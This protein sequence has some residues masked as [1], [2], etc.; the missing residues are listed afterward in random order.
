MTNAERD[1][2]GKNPHLPVLVRD[3]MTATAV[4]V[5]PT[6][7]VKD[8]AE[9]LLD[10]DIRCVPVVDVGNHL[11]GVVSEADLICR[12]GCPSIRSHN[13]SDLVESIAV[14]HRHHGERAEGLTAGEI[15]TENVI[16]CRPDEPVAIV[17]RR[18]LRHELRTL[19]VTQ[20]GRLMG[21]LS[22]HDVLRLFDRPDPEV[23][24]RVADLLADP[25]WSP[26]DHHVQARVMDGVVTLTGTVHYATEVDAVGS[27]VGQLPGVIEVVNRVSAEQPGAK[28][29]FT[30]YDES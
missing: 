11:V 2:R 12:E 28:P 15:M 25:L 18:M 5:E 7:T 24:E 14:E 21:V 4:T 29:A 1:S 27:A 20:D 13:L 10:R 16:T 19:P 26:D 6:A 23:R 3:L 17:T 8:I 22:R 30:A 9:V